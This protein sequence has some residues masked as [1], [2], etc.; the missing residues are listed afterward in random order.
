MIHESHLPLVRNK[1]HQLE[2]GRN[3]LS[4]IIAVSKASAVAGDVTLIALQSLG[5]R[6]ILNA[7]LREVLEI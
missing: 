4:H 2:A 5:S 3:S 7:V 1:R 6:E